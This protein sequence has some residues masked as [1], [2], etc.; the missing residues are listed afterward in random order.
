MTERETHKQR[1][2]TTE[3]EFPTVGEAT[4]LHCDWGRWRRDG[5]GVGGEGRGGGRRRGEPSIALNSPRQE[6]GPQRLRPRYLLR[7]EGDG[8]G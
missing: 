1:E 2:E 3:V 5:K 8:G 4:T 6:E 7:E